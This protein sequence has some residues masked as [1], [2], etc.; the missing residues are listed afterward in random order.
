MHLILLSGNAESGKSTLAKHLVE[1]YDS[2]V[3]F[4]LGDKLK[5]L[6]FE[7][8]KIFNIPIESVEELYDTESKKKYRNYLQ[9]IGTEC[10]R[11]VFGDDFWCKMLD[12][13]IEDCITE[14]LNV[15][16]SDIRY[17]NEQDYFINNY[18]NKLNVYSIKVNRT[19][20]KNNA[21][22]SEQQKHSSEIQINELSFDYVINNDMTDNYFEEISEVMWKIYTH[23]QESNE[24]NAINENA[25]NENAINENAI[26]AQRLISKSTF[27]PMP[28]FSSYEL[29]K[30]G[31]MDVLKIIQEIRPEFETSLVSSTGHCADIHSLDYNNNIKYVFEI[32]HKLTITK[33]DVNKF[34]SDIINVQ[35]MEQSSRNI[36]G[37]FI[38]LNSET[39]PSIGKISISKDKIYLTK[40][41]FSKSSLDIIFKMIET[42]F[43]VLNETNVHKS[44]AKRLKYEIPHNVLELLVKLRSE[45]AMLNKE[46]E[47]YLNMKSN[48]EKNLNSIQELIGKLVLKEQ[49]IKFI[50]SEFSD[51]LPILNDD[52]TISEE[53]KMKEYIK[54]HKKNTI[55]KKELLSL[56]PTMQTKIA[57]MK[58]SDLIDEYKK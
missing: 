57:S 16:I 53:E 18:K 31:E 48:T 26:N 34:E 42:Y 58:L 28:Q 51:I 10:C 23:E 12:K 19:D 41:Y 7:L 54:T 4:A 39:I 8:L 9:K 27:Q 1:E 2:Y 17:K 24:Q 50:N 52:L 45:Y 40:N 49:F 56:F 5:E 14:D 33:D 21:L 44:E 47:I 55:K 35:K 3:E 15:I 38:S 13:Y 36:I 46:M 30:I 20:G 11:K 6:T 29:G 32:K 25:I 37:V 43:D 22:T